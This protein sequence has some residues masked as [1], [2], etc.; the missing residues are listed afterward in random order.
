VPHPASEGDAPVAAMCGFHNVNCPHGFL[1]AAPT[2]TCLCFCVSEVCV[3]VSL[4]ACVLAYERVLVCVC[5][6]VVVVMFM[7]VLTMCTRPAALRSS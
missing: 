2:G 5:V 6:V 3:F 1:M 7:C 4:H